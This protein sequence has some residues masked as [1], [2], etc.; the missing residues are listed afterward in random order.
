MSFID[1][2][3][4]Q[5]KAAHEIGADL[6][7]LSVDERKARVE[8]LKAEIIRLDAESARKASGRQAAESFFRS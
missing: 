6:S 7:M 1:D 3:R 8:L 5:K 2:D 4:P